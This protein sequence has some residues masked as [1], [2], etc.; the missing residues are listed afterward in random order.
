MPKFKLIPI[1]AED[2]DALHITEDSVLE[3]FINSDGALVV[4]P[5]SDAGDYACDGDCAHC[6]LFGAGCA[7]KV[8]PIQTGAK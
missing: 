4:R 5:L 7:G 6:P 8:I 3:T 2:Y 1:P